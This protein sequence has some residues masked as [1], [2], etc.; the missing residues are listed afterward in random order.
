MLSP[1]NHTTLL[2]ISV[3]RWKSEAL[4]I[5]FKQYYTWQLPLLSIQTHFKT[6]YQLSKLSDVNLD[7]GYLS[8]C[9]ARS[10]LK[11]HGVSE[12]AII[13]PLGWKNQYSYWTHM[14]LYFAFRIVP[15][16]LMY[17]HFFDVYKLIQF[18]Y[19]LNAQ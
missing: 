10:K 8:C 7:E 5:V 16:F 6:S 4:L 18:F 14:G 19:T 13:G 1:I 15:R 12:I 11:P 9:E 2:V 17:K 3:N